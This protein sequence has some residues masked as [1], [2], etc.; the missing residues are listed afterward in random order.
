M[1]TV[2]S[3]LPAVLALEVLGHSQ[4]TWAWVHRWNK[5]LPGDPPN[6]LQP[7]NF[8]RIS[9]IG[10]VRPAPAGGGVESDGSDRVV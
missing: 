2:R 5:H 9:A 4:S 6:E 7:P 1:A 3:R 10:C 8:H